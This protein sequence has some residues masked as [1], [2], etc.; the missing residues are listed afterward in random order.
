M[1]EPNEQVHGLLPPS[2]LRSPRA[3]AVAG[4]AFALLSITS[5]ILIRLSFPDNLLAPA[6]YLPA[7]AQEITLAMSLV[8]FAGIAFLWFVAVVRDRM[9]N[10]EDQFFSTLFFGSGYLYLGT[11]FVAAALAGG[12]LVL[13][14]SDPD[15]SVA[16]SGIYP[17]AL[18]VANRL[19]SVFAMRM[20]G[21]FM[22]VLGTIWLR[23][24][25][26]PRWLAL[27]TYLVAVVLFISMNITL[28]VFL[29]FPAWV[30]V[31]SVAILVQN[32][33]HD[34]DLEMTES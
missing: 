24:G 26:L 4:I 23:T 1:V 30:F 19:N 29:V 17:L 8:P 2:K 32:Y 28:W 3:A 13:Y 12:A 10:Q 14:A 20:A 16:G 5:D 21:M 25:V 7:E 15:L 9:G 11:T 18:T 27:V 31:V 33:R 34:P 22:F 6:D